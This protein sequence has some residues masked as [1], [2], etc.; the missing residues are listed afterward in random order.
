MIVK[1]SCVGVVVIGRNEGER[2]VRCLESIPQN[3]GKIVYVD[4]G[5]TDDSLKI[6]KNA[7]A[8][9]IEL[10]LQIPFTAARARNEGLNAL[11]EDVS[12]S[13]VQFIDGD[14]ILN[15]NWINQA[16]DFLSDNVTV[17]VVCGRR[18][19]IS[20]EYSVYNRLCDWEWN[21]PIGP[22]KS[23]GGDA[24]MRLSALVGVG[25]FREAMI[26]GEEPELC[27]R[28]RKAGWGIWRLD[29]EMTLHDAAI[30]QF[31][32]WWKRAIRSGHAFAE[33]AALHGGPPE[34][35]NVAAVV[36]ILIWGLGL[37]ILVLA[38]SVFLSAWSVIVL[39]AYPAQILRLAQREGAD[40][41][42]GW[43]CAFFLT[44]G[45]FP[46]ALGLIKYYWRRWRNET[47]YLIEYK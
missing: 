10:D 32:Q 46:E 26:A 27:V 15:T 20:P 29:A 18:R 41:Y 4:S 2:L 36:R 23:C 25:G 45:K 43:E 38:L 7:G 11:L 47:A 9:P 1:L 44:L 40:H 14:C 16:L 24:M 28:L 33:G 42:Q 21:T 39:L 3:V 8:I 34:R 35:H 30:A 12:I 22:A 5:S 17:A 37:P 13:I 6:A 31:S 19:E